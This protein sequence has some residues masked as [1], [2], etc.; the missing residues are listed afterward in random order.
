MS[1][2]EFEGPTEREALEAAAKSFGVPVEDLDYTV[3]DEGAEAVFGLGGRPARIRATAA[4]PRAAPKAA[5]RGSEEE[6]DGDRPPRLTGP[7]PEKAAEAGRVMGELLER[8][9]FEARVEVHDEDDVIRVVIADA[10]GSTE[11]SDVFKTSRP[12][13]GSALQFVLN[14][15]VNRFPDDRKHIVLEAPGPSKKPAPATHGE[16]GDDFDPE[17]VT[18][19][20]L[21]AERAKTTGKVI[22]IHPMTAGDRRAIHQT[23]MEL[24]DVRTT[25]TG[26]GLYRKMHVVPGSGRRRNGGRRRGRGRR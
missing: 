16:G 2:R 18:L 11:L 20:E 21:L 12:P 19:A 1:G 25:S 5:P 15:I 6:S 26:E 10:E 9:G 17:L 23:V 8:M 22:T 4:A 7:A 24:D 3:L 14:K 13:V